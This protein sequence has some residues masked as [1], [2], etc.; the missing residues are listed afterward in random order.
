LEGWVVSLSEGVRLGCGPGSGW[1]VF[2][3]IFLFSFLWRGYFGFGGLLSV[4]LACGGLV[5]SPGSLGGF[6]AE[7]GQV[8][9][10]VDGIAV[11]LGYAS[12]ASIT[13]QLHRL[14]DG[15]VVGVYGLKQTWWTTEEGIMGHDVF[16]TAFGHPWPRSPR[17][18][19]G[20]WGPLTDCS[21]GLPPHRGER[22]SNTHP[23]GD[24]TGNFRRPMS[25][26]PAAASHATHAGL[27]PPRGDGSNSMV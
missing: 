4:W 9:V 11:V 25:R 22:S 13:F 23:C 6:Q 19:E 26:C 24:G 16:L 8:E 12:L 27:H 7:G 20:G 3:S 2:S 17:A 5:E 14:F 15:M 10:D 18:D 1:V 21:W